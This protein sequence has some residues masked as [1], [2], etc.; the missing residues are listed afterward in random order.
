MSDFVIFSF[1]TQHINNFPQVYTRE[2]KRQ[3][4]KK[5]KKRREKIKMGFMTN[6]F[7]KIQAELDPSSA[8][9]GST[10]PRSTSTS[11]SSS[12]SSSLNSSQSS[13]SMAS[14][15]HYDSNATRWEKAVVG[16]DTIV[17]QVSKFDPDGVDVVMVGGVALA[18]VISEEDENENDDSTQELTT[19]SLDNN[20]D[21]DADADATAVEWHR[22]IKNTEGLEELVTYKEPKGICPLGRAMEEVCTEA[23]SRDLKSRPCSVLVLTAGKPDDPELL[24]QTLENTAQQIAISGGIALSPLS[25]TFIQI[26]NDPDASQYLRQLDKKQYIPAPKGYSMNDAE[27]GNPNADDNDNNDHTIDLVDTMSYIEIKETM[28]EMAKAAKEAKKTGSNGSN[29]RNGA[30]VGALAGAALGIGGMYLA[31]KTKEKKRYKSGSWD[32]K[33]KCY[34][35]DEEIATLNVKDN[36]EG[37][38]TIDGL[39]D[40]MY[41]TYSH[42]SDKDEDFFIQ[43]T[44]PTGEVVT[45]EFDE[46]LFILEWSD[47]TRWEA[48]NKTS[49]VKYLGAATAGAAILGGTGYMV[50][51]K[52]FNKIQSKDQCDYIIIIDRSAN[53]TQ[54][55]K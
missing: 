49:V 26:G 15:M 14:V 55:D 53:M 43:F 36:K 27:D 48:L 6:A 13:L 52:F 31:G 42:G 8:G 39:I 18:G 23:L 47:G 44:D 46:K 38:I 22:G 33:W 3:K 32:G 24:E 19:T 7:E 21:A 20:A 41:G 4:L 40:T 10:T 50:D 54:R 45:G 34:Y 11:G 37:K 30:M 9:G 35:D 51:K 12:S 28:D 2:T 1:N 16:V 29:G 25:I 5:N 17:A